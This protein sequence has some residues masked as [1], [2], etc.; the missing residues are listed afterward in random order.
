MTCAAIACVSCRVYPCVTPL[1]WH[2][3]MFPSFNL[4]QAWKRRVINMG[5]EEDSGNKGGSGA[6]DTA[7]AGGMFLYKPGDLTNRYNAS[8]VV[9]PAS[10]SLGIVDI[11]QV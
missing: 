2:S 11:L 9:G 7:A 6:G 1:T 8:S 5:N 4:S 3:S 10:Y